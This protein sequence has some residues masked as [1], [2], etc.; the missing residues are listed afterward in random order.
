MNKHYA[1]HASKFNGLFKNATEYEQAAK[2]FFASSGDNVFEY[3]RTQGEFAGDLVKY[4]MN[5]NLFGVADKDGV[6][7]TFYKPKDGSKY[8]EEQLVKDFPTTQ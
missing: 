2:D 3:T 1:D 8:F 6:I 5:K 4:D 7:K